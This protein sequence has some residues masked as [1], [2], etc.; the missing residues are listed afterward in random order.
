MNLWR[1]DWR[2]FSSCSSILGCGGCRPLAL[3]PR[4][5]PRP[6]LDVFL[7]IRGRSSG[8][9]RWQSLEL[10]IFF[11]NCLPPR[12]WRGRDCPSIFLL[13]MARSCDPAGWAHRSSMS[14]LYWIITH[15]TRGVG[16]EYRS[17]FVSLKKRGII[18]RLCGRFIGIILW[19]FLLKVIN[20]KIRTFP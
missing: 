5:S 9:R 20:S 15:L 7:L 4:M 1:S 14:L 18:G 8:D 6:I 10:W 3:F 12:W 11:I 17:F 16:W 13:L 19:F 2:C